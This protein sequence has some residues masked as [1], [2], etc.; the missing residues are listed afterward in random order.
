MDTTDVKPP[1]LSSSKDPTSPFYRSLPL[2]AHPIEELAN[3]FQAWRKVIKSLL[4]YFTEVVSTHE[5]ETRIQQQLLNS[6]DFPFF[7]NGSGTKSSST[8]TT[9]GSAIKN[10]F[11]GYSQ[12]ISQEDLSI[13]QFF[14]P[15]N[16]GSIQDLPNQL[17]NYHKM[18]VLKTI[19]TNKELTTNIIPRL[20]ELRRDLL[21]K[22]KEIKSLSNDFENNIANEMA[23]TGQEYSKYINTIKILYSKNSTSLISG[24]N[25]PYLLKLNLDRQLARQIQEENYLLEAFQNLQGSGKELEIVVYQEVQVSINSY[26]KLI[27]NESQLTFDYLLDII[28][29]ENGLLTKQPDYEWDSFIDRDINFIDIDHEVLNFKKRKDIKTIKYDFNNDLSASSINS[30]YLERRSKY[31]K[32]YSRAY[33]LL[34]PCFLHEFKTIDRKKEPF[35]ILSISLDDC[36]ISEYI[37]EHSSINSTNKF[38]LN[39][40]KKKHSGS[41]HRSHN[42]VFKAENNKEM[43]LWYDKIKQLISLGSINARIQFL[44][45]S[46]E[47]EKH[48]NQ[49]L[50]S[51]PQINNQN[52]ISDN[53]S[54]VESIAST[55]A[56]APAFYVESSPNQDPYL[57]Q[58]QQSPNLQPVQRGLFTTDVNLPENRAIS[59][60]GTPRLSPRVNSPQVN[61]LNNGL[62]DLQLNQRTVHSRHSLPPPQ[63]VPDGNNLP[64][65]RNVRNSWYVGAKPGDIPSRNTS[66]LRGEVS[67]NINRVVRHS[68]YGGDPSQ[69]SDDRG[70]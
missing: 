50:Q 47:I 60:I 10:D 49:N 9:A 7:T 12:P 63:A 48:Q 61:A 52:I 16:K 40:S 70:L 23:L 31:L 41:L 68:Y 66:P 51:L 32:S 38:V 36:E 42:W 13:Q 1:N 4:V 67:P 34:T 30:G 37:K 65:N 20:E 15:F 27:G 54:I 39:A 44:N 11:D 2:N 35:P 18:L 8:S 58:Y 43:H 59:P 14:L 62:N 57:N 5:Q 17:I 26:L 22:I 69:Q 33:Y 53:S 24:K 25:D 6:V 64:Q 46:N 3:R 29:G 55:A 21:A 45:E 19:R 28:N 56:T